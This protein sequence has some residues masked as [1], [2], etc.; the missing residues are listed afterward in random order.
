MS[1]MV[2]CNIPNPFFTLL[3]ERYNCS[4]QPKEREIISEEV[5]ALR[6]RC[7]SLCRGL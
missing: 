3:P 7:W 4:I 2:L 1:F 5:S 6:C